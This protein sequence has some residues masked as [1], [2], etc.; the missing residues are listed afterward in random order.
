MLDIIMIEIM[1]KHLLM[2]FLLYRLKILL[3]FLFLLIRARSPVSQI[4]TEVFGHKSIDLSKTTDVN[5]LNHNSC[6]KPRFPISWFQD[7]E[8]F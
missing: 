8:I 1:I 6:S 4:L 3:F 7:I 5:M 2:H